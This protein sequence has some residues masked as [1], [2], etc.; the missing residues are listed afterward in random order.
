MVGRWRRIFFTSTGKLWERDLATEKER[1]WFSHPA[2]CVGMTVSRDS[3]LTACISKPSLLMLIPTAGG[4]ARELLRVREPECL[5]NN[6]VLSWTIHGNALVVTKR[7]TSSPWPELPL[8]L[9]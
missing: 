8:K 2:G 5:V 9:L 3:R 6:S 7:L 1:E 4:E